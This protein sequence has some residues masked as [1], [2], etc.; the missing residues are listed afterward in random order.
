M[1]KARPPSAGLCP[2]TTVDRDGLPVGE[3]GVGLMAGPSLP[4]GPV[5]GPSLPT[6]SISRAKMNT[7]PAWGM[8]RGL[9]PLRGRQQ[10]GFLV[11]LG[12]PER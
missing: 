9:Q 3:A 5:L 10:T 7:E 11:S 6:P 1:R 8:V 12:F 4:Q 2:I